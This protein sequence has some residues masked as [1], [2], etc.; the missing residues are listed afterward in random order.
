MRSSKN[1]TPSEQSA[2]TLREF[3]MLLMESEERAISKL[4]SKID[5]LMK[6]VCAVEE[7][8]TDIKAVQVQ[9]EMDI[10]KI[11]DVIATQQSHIEWLDERSRSCHLM[12]SNLPE[13]SITFNQKTL[14]SDN[15]KVLSL[16]NE[17][18]SPAQTLD[19]DDI[20]DVVRLGRPG[21]NPRPLKVKV[22]DEKCRNYIVRSGKFLNSDRIRS[23]FGRV[24]I[25]KDLSYFRRQEEKRLRMKRNELKA[26]YPEADVRLKSGKLYLGPAIKDI[27]DY[28]NQLF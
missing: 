16:I 2:F 1:A 8:I 28:K 26:S 25:N 17:I 24:Y 19:P 18:L 10:A 14:E 15:E 23:A 5:A 6:K 27:I 7:A 11:K 21:R 3:K 20:G 13:S 12:I 9:Q 22:V 4:N